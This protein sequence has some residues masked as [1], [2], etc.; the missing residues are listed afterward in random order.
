MPCCRHAVRVTALILR[1]VGCLAAMGT[2]AG[3]VWEIRRL[4]ASAGSRLATV[5]A[6][7]SHCALAAVTVAVAV[8]EALAPECLLRQCALLHAWPGRGLAMVFAAVTLHGGSAAHA[9][10]SPLVDG[11]LLCGYALAG[12]G[13]AYT[14]LGVVGA[15]RFA[16]TDE[17]ARCR[18]KELEARL[19]CHPL[20]HLPPSPVAPAS[21][22][23]FMPLSPP[24]GRSSGLSAV[25]KQAAAAAFKELGYD[26][27]GEADAEAITRFAQT[28]PT[29]RMLKMGV[30]L[31]DVTPEQIDNAFARL[32][33][34]RFDHT[35]E[36]KLTWKDWKCF[37][38]H[39]IV[40]SVGKLD[41]V[42]RLIFLL[43]DSKSQ[44]HLGKDEIERLLDTYY[45]EG[46]IFKQTDGARDGRI[47]EREDLRRHIYE[48]L[49]TNGDG[50]L[51]FDEIC[52]LFSG[53]AGGARV[54]GTLEK[55]A[56]GRRGSGL[57][58]WRRRW[59]VADRNGLAYWASR[60]E[61]EKQVT[62]KN[63]VSWKSVAALLANPQVDDH[64]ESKGCE[65]RCLL[66]IYDDSGKTLKLLL[67]AESAQ[68]RDRWVSFIDR[69]LAASGVQVR[70]S[71][72]P[73]SLA[74]VDGPSSPD[75]SPASSPTSSPRPLPDQ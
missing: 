58:N 8:G 45:A 25:D 32:A 27:Q 34:A 14:L 47:P 30:C 11:A 41:F 56:L 68:D 40:D 70:R 43:L 67:R 53:N 31:Q 48:S 18:R 22:D 60:Q 74:A 37:W 44:G 5:C 51:T 49:D 52:P 61:E 28:H 21:P 6:V 50:I 38:R 15:R 39:A 75:Q 12:C 10:P 16:D 26:K 71:L 23:G 59:F 69:Q 33:L 57:G 4:G 24:P 7:L 42:W 63:Y 73:V 65:S 19:R 9:P 54:Q 17:A 36:G 2:V 72:Q 62:P 29:A 3:R 55:Y 66:V 13:L 20:E 35:G 64:P 46:S 1:T